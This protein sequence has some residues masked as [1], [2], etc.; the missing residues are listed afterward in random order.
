[1][2]LHNKSI[3]RIK[4]KKKDMEC[5]ITWKYDNKKSIYKIIVNKYVNGYLS[6]GYSKEFYLNSL[7]ILEDKLDNFFNIDNCVVKLY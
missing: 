1:M 5:S 6:P 7:D 2:L 4:H 3:I